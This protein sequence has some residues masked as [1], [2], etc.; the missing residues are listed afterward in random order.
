M[1]FSPQWGRFALFSP[2]A[3]IGV[4]CIGKMFDLSSFYGI[5]TDWEVSRYALT[6]R[7]N[8]W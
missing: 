8:L 6:A 5:R 1:R 3:L 2:V 4:P 7:K